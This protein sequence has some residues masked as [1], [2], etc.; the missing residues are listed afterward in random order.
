MRPHENQRRTFRL[1][2][3]RLYCAVNGFKVV[4]ILNGMRVPAIRFETPGT[5]LRES[6]VSR[7]GKRDL[8]IIIEANQFAKPQMTGERCGLGR[9]P[10][11][12]I[13][14]AGQHVSVMADD[15]VSRTVVVRGK[16]VLR[17]RNADTIG[18][19]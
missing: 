5:I 19:S 15:L 18:E 9:Y 3:S 7:S 17:D 6:D 12:Q 13:T 11:H 2:L 14:V 1:G 10:F 16:I 4:S 8:V